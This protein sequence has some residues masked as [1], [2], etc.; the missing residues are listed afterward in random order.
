M[1][2]TCTVGGYAPPVHYRRRA[3]AYVIAW[4]GAGGVGVAF[5]SKVPQV[6]ICLVV[7]GCSA[8]HFGRSQF[9]AEMINQ[10]VLIPLPI[11]SGTSWL[12][13][14]IATPLTPIIA[15]TAALFALLWA[16]PPTAE[17][18]NEHSGVVLTVSAQLLFSVPLS[19]LLCAK[20]T[21]RHGMFSMTVEDVFVIRGRGL[22]AG[23]C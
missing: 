11:V 20:A 19:T 22:V 16:M 4:L 21:Q 1:M 15:V 13:N 18:R 9:S 3:G 17:D 2:S 10:L 12:P 23:Q 14:I 6:A 8:I 7:I 5:W